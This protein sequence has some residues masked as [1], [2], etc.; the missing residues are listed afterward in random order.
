MQVLSMTLVVAMVAP[1]CRDD[2]IDSAPAG[3]PGTT[4]EFDD[5]YV[6]FVSNFEVKIHG[7]DKQDVLAEGTYSIVDGFI[8]I[9][10]DDRVR[11]G[12]WDGERLMVDGMVGRLK[13]TAPE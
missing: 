7:D 2:I 13:A 9:A 6:T 3:L 1:A 10:L 5:F 12:S 4:W 8:E 11:A